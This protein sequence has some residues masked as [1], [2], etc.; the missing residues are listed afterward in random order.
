[1]GTGLVHHNHR[2]CLAPKPQVPN[3]PARG[4]V[5]RHKGREYRV[6]QEAGGTVYLEPRAPDGGWI[7]WDRGMRSVELAGM[8]ATGESVLS[9]Q[10]SVRQRR[11]R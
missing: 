7:G 8:I 6:T 5:V 2:Q 10:K 11:L 3:I 9:E 4:D 1:M